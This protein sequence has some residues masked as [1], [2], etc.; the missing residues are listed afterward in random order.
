[1]KFAARRRI[2]THTDTYA[3]Y[4]FPCIFPGSICLAVWNGT[5]LTLFAVMLIARCA[6]ELGRRFGRKV[7]FLAG[8]GGE[9]LRRSGKE[10]ILSLLFRYLR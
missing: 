10:S 4:A 6:R 3:S 8:G 5:K 2:R 9:K 7:K 1:M